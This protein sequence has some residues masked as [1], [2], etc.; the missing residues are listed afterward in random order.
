MLMRYLQRGTTNFRNSYQLLYTTTTGAEDVSFETAVNNDMIDLRFVGVLERFTESL[1]VL[2]E[3]LGLSLADV[4][5]IPAKS[6]EYDWGDAAEISDGT[7]AKVKALFN[8][9][10]DYKYIDAASKKLD[11]LKADIP[12]Y[13][14]KLNELEQH[15]SQAFDACSAHN[16]YTDEQQSCLDMYTAETLAS[17]GGFMMDLDGVEKYAPLSEESRRKIFPAGAFSKSTGSF[18]LD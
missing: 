5:Y 17:N 14:N 3:M 16:I 8:G 10:E 11:M 12:D 6:A 13:E 18:E 2:K 4:L 1:V 9:A 15:L 7:L